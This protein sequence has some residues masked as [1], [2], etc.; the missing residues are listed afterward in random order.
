MTATTTK[1]FDNNLAS[2]HFGLRL[3]DCCGAHSTFHM[4]GPD[5]EGYTLCCKSCFHEV[6]TGEGDGS[7]HFKVELKAVKYHADMSEETDCF[8]ANLYLNG[9]KVC[10]V[11]NQGQGGPNFY[12][13]SFKGKDGKWRRNRQIEQ[14]LEDWADGQDL[15][16]ELDDV[17]YDVESEKLDWIVGQ[18]F[19]NWL[20]LRDLK[21]WCKTMTVFQ[22]EGD[23]GASHQIKMP[24]DQE[25]K[26]Y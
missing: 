16:Y 7:E 12:D 1:R 24:F 3:T 9:K 20:E 2:P 26:N 15:T 25:M 18:M 4:E 21:R 14:T 6:E 19:T 11:R 13:W 10:E 17:I 22:L 8:S 23:F 5:A